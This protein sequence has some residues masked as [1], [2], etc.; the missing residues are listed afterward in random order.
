MQRRFQ[1]RFIQA[2]LEDNLIYVGAVR[3]GEMK[4]VFYCGWTNNT[5]LS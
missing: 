3:S 2:G 1:E 4:N 5:E